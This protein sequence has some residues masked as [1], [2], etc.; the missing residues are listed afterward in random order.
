VTGYDP[1]G[2]ADDTVLVGRV[3]RD[4][5]TVLGTVLN[6]ACHPTTLAWE[7][8][9]L[10]PDYVAAA[11]EVLEEATEGAPCLFLLGAC[12]ELA[13]AHQ[14]VGDPAVADGHGRRLGYA[15]RSALTSMM[16]A[17]HDL[18]FDGIVESGAP[19]AVWLPARTDRAS[20]GAAASA[21]RLPLPIKTD[22]PQLDTIRSELES[23]SEGYV[24]E[25]L[26]RKARLR[27]S[28]GD[29]ETYPFSIWTWRMGDTVF[30][31]LPAEAFS[32]AQLRLRQAFPDRNVVVMNLVNGSIGYLPPAELYGQDIYE[33]WQTPLD[34]GCFERV[35]EACQASIEAL[36]QTP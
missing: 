25:R 21:S 10:S 1:A 5:G 32:I 20:S 31:G 2:E 11:R 9:L 33:V 18:V 27:E 34:A 15:A 19:L 13:P 30:V 3:S 23:A 17:G 6:Y 8:E 36:V 29:G 22:Y 28:I 12:G 24:R 35:L 26:E 16:P 14:Y 4:D 7:N